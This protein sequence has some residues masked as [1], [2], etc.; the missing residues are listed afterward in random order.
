MNNSKGGKRHGAGR[1]KADVKKELFFI[2]DEERELILEM[3]KQTRLKAMPKA[4]TKSIKTKVSESNNKPLKKSL[5]EL[6]NEL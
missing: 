3:R 5:K 6:L 4:I 2:T 1:P